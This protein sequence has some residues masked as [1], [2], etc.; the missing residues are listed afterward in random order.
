MGIGASLAL[1]FIK[2]VN[3][4]KAERTERERL[5]QEKLLENRKNL[6]TFVA[7]AVKSNMMEG[8]V[9]GIVT[10][11][12]EAGEITSM[13]QIL[14]LVVDLNAEA[15]TNTITYGQISFP[16][17]N[18]K[19]YENISGGDLLKAG[20]TWLNEHENI[21]SNAANRQA[22]AEYFAQDD[23]ARE[24]FL[25]NLTRYTEHYISGNIKY[26]TGEDGVLRG[27]YDP[28]GQFTSVYDFAKQLESPVNTTEMTHTKLI[29]EAAALGTIGDPKT[30]LVLSFKDTGGTTQSSVVQFSQSEYEAITQLGSNLGFS[31][32]QQLVDNFDDLLIA[33]TP[34]EA[35]SVLRKAAF[36]QSQ[37]YN[38][39]TKTGGGSDAMRVS[40]G[41]ELVT[42]YGQ[43]RYRMAQ[44][45]APIIKLEEDPSAASSRLSKKH[46]RS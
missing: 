40:L 18:E 38:A 24:F 34:D 26:N 45:V 1:G 6:T 8:Q 39:L 19:Y 7:D 44:A 13:S 46:L 30:A 37:G 11:A 5:A 4:A 10:G 27:F 17:T 2:G 14:P 23:D 36:F 32:P 16:V 21:L 43:D 31:S 22:F 42:S 41:Q 20:N 29:D 28:K 9:G 25:Q 12:I 33:D 3:S 15:D 35:Y